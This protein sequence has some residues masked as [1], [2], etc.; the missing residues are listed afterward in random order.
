MDKP[1]IVYGI[2][3]PEPNA[4]HYTILKAME[5]AKEY[6]IELVLVT[7]S[8]LIPSGSTSLDLRMTDEVPK[9]PIEPLIIKD[10]RKGLDDDFYPLETLKNNYPVKKNW[11]R[12]T[13]RYK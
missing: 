11:K 3:G 5:V 6:N 2:I 12:K 7:S 8:D 1:K 9:I 4:K 13:K 10:Y